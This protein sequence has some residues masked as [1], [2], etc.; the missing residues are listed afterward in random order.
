MTK[1]Q[2]HAGGLTDY[3]K[4]LKTKYLLLIKEINSD[5]KLTASEKLDARQKALEEFEVNKKNIYRN[6]Y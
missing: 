6:L 4:N 2:I 5:A 3:I 1:L